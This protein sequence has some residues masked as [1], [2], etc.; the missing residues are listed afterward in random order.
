MSR[1]T[2]SL[3]LRAWLLLLTAVAVLPLTLFAGGALLELRDLNRQAT[4]GHLDGRANAIAAKLT[5]LI[6][7]SVGALGAL[8]QTDA[9]QR[10]DMATLY[11]SAKRVLDTNPS[12]Q[13][14]SLID[15]EGRMV[16]VTSRP[17]GAPSF[18][19]NYP[20]LVDEVF[21]T[22][23]P[24]LSGVF[25]TPIS[26]N[27]LVAVSVPMRREGQ[28][29]HVLRMVMLAKTISQ[30]LIDEALPAAWLAGILDRQ[31]IFVARNVD[32]EN[33]VGRPAS[34][35][36]QRAMKRREH[37]TFESISLE[38]APIMAVIVPLHQGD[39]FLGVAVPDTLLNAPVWRNLRVFAFFALTGLLLSVV[40]SQWMATWLVRQLRRTTALE[41]QDS[42]IS[43]LL[44]V[45]DFAQFRETQAAVRRAD[46]SLRLELE[47]ATVQ[48]NDAAA[49]LDEAPCGYF[50]LDADTQI[51][52]VNK[53]ALAWLGHTKE[54]VLGN[55]L[56]NH[57]S[58]RS[59]I[60]GAGELQS[61]LKRGS[62]NDLEFEL[63]SKDGS[64]RWV[65]LNANMIEGSAGDVVAWRC[66]L[67]DITERKQFEQS[68]VASH[69]QLSQQR[70]ALE[71]QLRSREDSHFKPGAVE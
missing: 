42:T 28:I 41:S 68:L 5:A 52:N 30:V 16:F 9:A 20:E 47:Q 24:N 11:Q 4:L 53:T 58:A 48:R 34:P 67:V 29:T 64:L 27:K 57:F 18:A 26:D 23:K 37:F 50:A 22:G 51:L 70:E 25:V 66:V 59:Q 46:E 44:K 6:D 45:T 56:G 38:G 31:G 65:L 49:L 2:V 21:K 8:G 39:W 15:I 40:L 61:R 33:S 7:A 54:E 43:S 13:A 3:S 19:P 60:G 62:A 14:I 32:V 71:A 17:Y 1:N 35:E 69:N 12:F 10:G 55:R 63:C 36:F